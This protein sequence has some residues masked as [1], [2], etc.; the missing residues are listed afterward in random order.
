[1]GF[2]IF[3][4][5]VFVLFFTLI[6]VIPWRRRLARRRRIGGQ[7]QELARTRGWTFAPSDPTYV[8]LWQGD[9]FR[10]P[11]SRREAHNVVSGV[12]N[13]APFAVFDYQRVATVFRGEFASFE[14]VTVACAQLAAPL[15]PLEVIRKRGATSLP[16]KRLGVH[17]GH[18]ELDRRYVVVAASTQVPERLL[19][20]ETA[21]L[22]LHHDVESLVVDGQVA[23]CSR[24]IRRLGRSD[25][26]E[27]TLQQLFEIVSRLPAGSSGVPG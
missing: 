18:P 10:R 25:V 27:A 4:A 2:V 23:A 20:P 24:T 11:G 17:T 16:A 21:G 22:I 26:L 7:R 13:G 19:T 5:V 8:N 9:P 3:V 15:P 14:T 6:N 1:M 12:A